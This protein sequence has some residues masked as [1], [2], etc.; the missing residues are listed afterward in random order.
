MDFFGFILSVRTGR[1]HSLGLRSI[2]HYFPKSPGGFT[3]N[4]FG[5]PV[6]ITLARKVMV[7]LKVY[8]NTELLANKFQIRPFRKD[9]KRF[10]LPEMKF[11][12]QFDR[13]YF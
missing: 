13:P 5:R 11:L 8:G 3:F 9:V 7:M 4:T 10:Y 12:F 1:S 6:F 2:R